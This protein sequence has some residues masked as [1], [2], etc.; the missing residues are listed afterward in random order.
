MEINYRKLTAMLL[1]TFLRRPLLLALLNVVARPLQQLHDRHQQ[2]RENRLYDLA[3]T[4]QVCHIKDALNHQFGVGNYAAT[5]DY[6]AGFLIEDIS[7]IGDWLLTY[8]E[9][10]AFDMDHL[11]LY[12]TDPTI[13][14]DEEVILVQT[15]TFI[16]YVPADVDY[17]RYQYE[18]QNI[19]DRFRPAGRRAVIIQLT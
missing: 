14:Y 6:A 18:I 19:I 8:D 16:V 11:V 9:A 13:A 17:L 4:G 10:P 2:A 7:A 3:H 12:D 5:P 1:P 15:K